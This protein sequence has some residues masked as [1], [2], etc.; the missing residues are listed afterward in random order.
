MNATARDML[1]GDRTKPS[2][3]IGTSS[4]AGV[5]DIPEGKRAEEALQ[6]ELAFSE[7]MV[8]VLS[9]LGTCPS[10]EIDERVVE[11]LGGIAGFVGADHAYVLT[12]APDRTTWS[13]THEW[14][15]PNVNG[16]AGRYQRIPFGTLR[17]SESRLLADEVILLNS[18]D[19]YPAEAGEERRKSLREGEL[20]VI[21]VPVRSSAGGVAGCVGVDSHSGAVTWR[22]EDVVRLRMVADVIGSILERKSAEE[23]LRRH[24]EFL[25]TLQ[26]ITLDLVSQRDVEHLLGSILERAVRLA[27]A[28]GGFVDLAEPGQK[29]LVPT[30][31]S[32][33]MTQV[34][35]FSVSP[36][37][38]LTGRVWETG[39]PLTVADY[40]SWPGRIPNYPRGVI[41]SIVGVPLVSVGG[42]TGVVALVYAPSADRT[43]DA[44]VVG[45][46]T[47]L[48]RFATIALENAQAYTTARQSLSL[49]EATLES[50][51]D[52]ILV[53]DQNGR[54]VSYNQRFAEMW[55]IPPEVLQTHDDDRALAFVIEQLADPE[56]F[57]GKVREL[58]A[59]PEAESMD[60][61]TFRDGR[62]FERFSRPQRLEGRPTGRAWSFRDVTERK[63]SERLQQATYRIS[64]SAHEAASLEEFF[65]A[66]HAIVSELMPARNFYIAL[67][68]RQSDTISFPYFVDEYDAPPAPK[69]L[70]RGLTEYVL[71]TGQPILASPEVFEE[72][73]RRGE[74]EL[75]GAPS[76]DW[77]G[78]PLR[79][80]Q[81]TIGIVVVQS[82]T[83][84]VRFRD[85]DRDLLAFVSTQLA[86]AIERKAAEA[87]I[88]ASERRYRLLFERGLA[89]MYR[90]TADG[91][92]VECN[93][94]F[95]SLLGYAS[96]GEVR[97]LGP[98][99]LFANPTERQA[100]LKRLR[101]QHI[102]V[103]QE[104]QMRRSDDTSIWVLLNESLVEEASAPPI[105]D[106]SL[107]NITDL[108]LAEK[109]NWKLVHHDSLTGLPNRML[110]ND[111]LELAIQRARRGSQ[112]LAIMFL[113]LDDF[114]HVNDTLGHSAGD[115]L[116][117]QV[118]GRLRHILRGEDT[119]ARLGGDEFLLLLT[120]VR[121]PAGVGV[122]A[123]KVL[124]VFES[125]FLVKERELFLS[126][127]LGIVLYPED[128]SDPEVL[129]ANVDIAMY[130]AK[131]IGRN[132]FQFFTAEMQQHALERAL[133][134][135]GLRRALP[136]GEFVLHYQP[137]WDLGSGRIVG[138]EALVRW[139]HSEHG[140]LPPRDFVALAEDVGLIV[141]L[142]AW[143]LR[144]ACE[145]TRAW[146]EQNLGNLTIAV[147]LSAR[148]VQS[149]EF[150]RQVGQILHETGL[151][152]TALDLEITESTAM[153]NVEATRQVLG[154]LSALGVRISIDDFGT[155]H[156]SLSYLKHFPINRL[157]IDRSF[158]N[159]I[160]RD[161]RDRAIVAG[162][163]SIAHN[164]GVRVVAEGVE[165]Q[166][167]AS[168]LANLGC[169]EVQGFF[170]GAPVPESQVEKLLAEG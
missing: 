106:G 118:G 72:L 26:E 129:L 156:S 141:P 98:A 114:K 64:E 6:R 108:K 27:G 135:S 17:W 49:L 143:V 85:T 151:P 54:I 119:L 125:P 153:Q 113:D 133:L 137:I 83:E 107:M 63:R 131:K 39:R 4:E 32:G 34:A 15:G 31:A 40:D 90:M 155:G 101:A 25:R 162:V 89:G 46:L 91:Y 130:R 95:A 28:S 73:V 161:T 150:V 124:A 66:V 84:G 51:T 43:F 36:R 109:R 24:N 168:L 158:I 79:T 12:F 47:Q 165:T 148:Q 9:R 123:Q 62:V 103:N 142:G 110:F 19:D 136:R 104:V 71:R 169:D 105:V 14:C 53:V 120:G 11:A 115:E 10:G 45:R 50:T 57:L 126:A 99:E 75:I 122:M 121:D 117:V 92:L 112:R 146:R 29:R 100:G 56:A 18:P 74:V 132:N 164:L 144:R 170:F 97:G 8:A 70:G 2:T 159:G 152:P 48:T 59:A 37:E 60:V 128:G 58:Y 69:P 138:L 16:E 61:L 167:Q 7:L 147:N 42:V 87:A 86:M 140:L 88:R 22:P 44:E 55:R 111:R 68:D 13:A 96:P 38:G 1:A 154:Q 93:Q 102:A 160:T 82:Y 52:G 157:K 139:Q 134:E 81:E 33:V 5:T 80:A 67:H 65:R 41:G 20:S 116:L 78:I 30:V 3:K 77:L 35:R 94:T 21:S 145:R 23:A 127:S 166:E 76:V 149:E 163:L